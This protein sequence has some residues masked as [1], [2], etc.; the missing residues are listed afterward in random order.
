MMKVSGQLSL[1]ICVSLD[2]VLVFKSH[3]AVALRSHLS[4]RQL[5]IFYF[6]AISV[7]GVLVLRVH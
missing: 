3:F 4:M 2:T 6:I 7:H 5:L 1:G